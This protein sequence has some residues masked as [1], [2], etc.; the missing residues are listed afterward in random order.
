MRCAKGWG[1]DVCVVKPPLPPDASQHQARVLTLSF[2]S[3]TMRTQ[4][5]C[6]IPKPT[7]AGPLAGQQSNADT[8][9]L[10]PS[11]PQ[12]SDTAPHCGAP[13]RHQALTP[14][15]SPQWLPSVHT[16]H[17]VLPLGLRWPW[18]Y[19]PPGCQALHFPSPLLHHGYLPTAP[20]G[21]K[22]WLRGDH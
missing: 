10:H 11:A 12:G 1:H 15:C 8:G 14:C 6:S 18:P 13:C 4:R 20:R 22:G 3:P 7:A 9:F 5:T 19:L 16:A 17:S 2:P 21:D